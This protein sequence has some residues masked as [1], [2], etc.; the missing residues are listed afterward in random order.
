MIDFPASPTNGQV[1][2]ATNGVVYVYS[3]AYSSWLAQNAPSGNM[4]INGAGPPSFAA[5]KGTLYSNTTATTTTT[6]LYINTDGGT[7]WANFTASA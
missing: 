4:L 7:T 3:T 5:V 1:F 2:S 6:R